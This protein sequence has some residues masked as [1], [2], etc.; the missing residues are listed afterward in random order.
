MPQFRLSFPHGAT[1]IVVDI[2]F[3]ALAKLSNS[4]NDLLGIS[5]AGERA[6]GKCP[7]VLGLAQLERFAR[8]GLNRRPARRR[9]RGVGMADGE[10]EVERRMDAV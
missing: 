8:S 7:V 3:V 10:L 6:F 1:G 9:A 2:V 4:A 5:A